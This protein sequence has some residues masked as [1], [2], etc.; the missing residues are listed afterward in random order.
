MDTLNHF[1]GAFLQLYVP[2]KIL[3][4]PD[5]A[6]L[7]ISG[8]NAIAGTLPDIVAD[9]DSLGKDKWTEFSKKW[10]E[11]SHAFRKWWLNLIPG[12]MLHITLD[13]FGHGYGKR[14]YANESNWHYFLPWKWREAMWLE[15][16]TW[17]I[18]IILLGAVIIWR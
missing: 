12:S 17:L 3:G 15:S 5:I 1:T 16:V 18:N 8:A 13:T 9:L 10:Y 11:D 2:L 14:W 6:A 7:P 4:I